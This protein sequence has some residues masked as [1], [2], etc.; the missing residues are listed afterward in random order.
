MSASLTDWYEYRD[1][2]KVEAEA[3]AAAERREL[4]GTLL[5]MGLALDDQFT[6]DADEDI[7]AV[8]MRAG[9]VQPRY[10]E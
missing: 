3:K 5:A 4:I 9:E 8:M 6:K 1:P 7:R 10:G 2:A